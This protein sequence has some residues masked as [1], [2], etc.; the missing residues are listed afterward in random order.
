MSKTPGRIP[1]DLLGQRIGVHDFSVEKT[2]LG[3]GADETGNR[4]RRNRYGAFPAEIHLE[5][6]QLEVEFDDLAH[7]LVPDLDRTA[8]IKSEP[9]FRGFEFFKG[10]AAADNGMFLQ[11]GL[12]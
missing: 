10:T 11:D 2:S 4:A 5:I 3:Q 7:A 9:G 12:Q 1:A 8:D 6:P